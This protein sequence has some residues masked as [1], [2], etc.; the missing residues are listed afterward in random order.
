[1]INK[2]NDFPQY[3]TISGRKVF[4]KIVSD[5]QFIEMSWIGEKQMTFTVNAIQYPEKLRIMD[6]LNCEDP[7]V[8]LESEHLYLFNR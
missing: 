3:R 8:V 6:M 2:V 1:M 7:F 5:T 4:Y